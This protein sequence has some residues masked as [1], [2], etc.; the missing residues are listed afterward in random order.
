MRLFS[1]IQKA[2]IGAFFSL[3]LA[4]MSGLKNIYAI[5]GIF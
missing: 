4:K 1:N 3:E 2:P 5:F